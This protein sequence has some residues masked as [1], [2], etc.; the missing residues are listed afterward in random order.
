MERLPSS[1]VTD[2]ARSRENDA[3]DFW[4]QPIQ[5][6]QRQPPTSRDIYEPVS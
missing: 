1:L 3:I 5:M 2:H 4:N 6:S